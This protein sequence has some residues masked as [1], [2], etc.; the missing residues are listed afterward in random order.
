MKYIR[1]EL[2]CPQC[3]NLTTIQRKIGKAK[4]VGHIKDLYCYVCKEVTKQYEINDVT[5]FLLSS[6]EQNQ[7][8]KEIRKLILERKYK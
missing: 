6:N 2:V 8:E 5:K 7:E 3:G 4:K 1:T